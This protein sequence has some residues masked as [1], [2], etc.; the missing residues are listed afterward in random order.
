VVLG[1]VVPLL[2]IT[3]VAVNQ[4]RALLE[5]LQ[6]SLH[7]QNAAFDPA[8]AF[9]SLTHRVGLDR[10]AIVEWARQ[11][12]SE[13]ASMGAA[14][15]STVDNFLRPRLVPGRVGL[16]EAGRIKT[17]RRSKP[18]RHITNPGLS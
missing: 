6:E 10:T 1:F 13:L 17:I 2:L 9:D 15:V 4:F 18:A 5:W 14:V 12:S 11:H 7:S 3:G 16:S 8:L